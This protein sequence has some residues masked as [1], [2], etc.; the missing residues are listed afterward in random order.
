MKHGRGPKRINYDLR[1]KLAGAGF[2]I[3]AFVLVFRLFNLQLLSGDYY[4]RI[5]AKQMNQKEVTSPE[6]GDIYFSNKDGDLIS[7]ATQKRIYTLTINPRIIKTPENIFNELLKVIDIKE[8]DFMAKVSKANDPFEIIA[9]DLS[10]EDAQTIEE[11]NL[12]GVDISVEDKRFYPA[13]NLASHILGFV[14][15]KALNS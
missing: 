8:E 4:K 10:K 11:L 2:F 6:R 14:G 1:I 13:D 15:Y 5:S 3:L 7:A 12:I 9:K